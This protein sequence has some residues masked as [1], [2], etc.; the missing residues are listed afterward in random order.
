MT[1]LPAGIGAGV[2][3]SHGNPMAWFHGIL[4]SY[5]LRPNEKFGQK[6]ADHVASLKQPYVG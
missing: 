5:I 2:M 1:H 4:M 6:L 3:A